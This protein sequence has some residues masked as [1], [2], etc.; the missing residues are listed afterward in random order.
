MHAGLELIA[1][2]ARVLSPKI[3]RIARSVAGLFVAPHSGGFNPGDDIHWVML[4]AI[5]ACRALRSISW[6]SFPGRS[7]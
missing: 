7:F 1:F 3:L 5:S 6:R 2:D 4:A